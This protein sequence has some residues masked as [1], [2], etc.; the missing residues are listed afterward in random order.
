MTNVIDAPIVT[1]LLLNPER[2]LEA[3]LG[4]LSDVVII[5]Y[6]HDGEE[7]FASSEAN[8][9]EVVWLLERAKLQLLRMGDGDNAS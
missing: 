5:G 2:V 6:T 8:G 4:K 1:R 7:Y 3:A 9:A